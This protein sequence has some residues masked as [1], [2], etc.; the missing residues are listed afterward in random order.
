MM[1]MMLYSFQTLP[2][3]RHIPGSLWGSPHEDFLGTTPRF[4]ERTVIVDDVVSIPTLFYFN[5]HITLRVHITKSCKTPN[6]YNPG[7]LS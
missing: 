2:E 1:D 4:A 6:I 7:A 3:T 5:S